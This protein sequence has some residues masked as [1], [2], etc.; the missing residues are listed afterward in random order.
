M[1]AST[2]AQLRAAIKREA[3]V[4]A[5]ANLDTLIDD[6]VV[7]IM[8]DY[9]N[10]GRFY[11]LLVE[12]TAIPLVAGQQSYTL[13][14]DFHHLNQVRYGRGPNPATFRIVD[15]QPES[16]RQTWSQGWPRFY[17]LV[18][19]PK[20]SFFPYADIV[21]ADQLKIDY[22]RD[23]ATLWTTDA[24]VFPV[25]R[26]ESAVKKDAIAR[27]QRFHTATQEAQLTDA[28]GRSSFNAADAGSN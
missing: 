11:E 3:R 22:Y 21:V 20:I 13:P 16:V 2:K 15:E 28:D 19:G 24:S 1:A 25:P 18:A 17:R 9:C 27:V 6:I 7:D 12:G 26:L 5:N 8:R 14:A 23:P 10:L 4:L